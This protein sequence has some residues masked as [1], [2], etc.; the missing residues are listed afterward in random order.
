MVRGHD[1]GK[2]LG[3]FKVGPGGSD[4]H[5]VVFQGNSGDGF[6]AKVGSGNRQKLRRTDEEFGPILR[7]VSVLILLKKN[8]LFQSE[9]IRINEVQY[10]T[11]AKPK[12]MHCFMNHYEQGQLVIFL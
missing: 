4:V 6:A 7:E 1:F 3:D 11:N 8:F 5:A 10:I 12:N 2:E 9:S